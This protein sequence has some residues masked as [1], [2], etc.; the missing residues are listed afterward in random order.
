MQTSHDRPAGRTRDESKIGLAVG[1]R[2]DFKTAYIDS[3]AWRRDPPSA[4]R[5]QASRPRAASSSLLH[6]EDVLR[7]WPRS[8]AR[9]RA[10]PALPHGQ[11][12]RADR[13]RPASPSFTCSSTPAALSSGAPASLASFAILRLSIA[14]TLPDRRAIERVPML[15]ALAGH[16]CLLA[17]RRCA[18]TWPRLVRHR[19]PAPPSASPRPAGT[20]PQ[21]QS[22]HRRGAMA[23]CLRSSRSIGRALQH[24][25]YVVSFKRM[26][27]CRSR[28]AACRLPGR[29]S[30]C[31]PKVSAVA[32]RAC[33]KARGASRCGPWPSVRPAY[34][35][36]DASILRRSSWR[37]PTRSI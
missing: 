10:R 25:Q 13:R 2:T 21:A 27:Q 17:P 30:P 18:G 36:R 34:R 5:C 12:I 20:F 14:S 11:C 1:E 37:A 19:A 33:D 31:S 8:R 6:V 26:V 7:S 35:A 3:E 4:S 15:R 9:R 23:R 28:S 32:M 16:A 24:R 22:A 29:P